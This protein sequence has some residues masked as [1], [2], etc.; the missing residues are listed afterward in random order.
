[1]VGEA[2]IEPA[3]S[4]ESRVTTCRHQPT[5][6]SLPKMTIYAYGAKPTKTAM[7]SVAGFDPATSHFQNEHS[8]KLS[9]TLKF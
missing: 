8:T 6:A 2:G 5:V 3:S 7:V 1:M 9:Y 4:E